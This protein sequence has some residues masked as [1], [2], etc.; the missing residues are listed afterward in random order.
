[1]Y[2]DSQQ[3]VR[4]QDPRL[5]DSLLI[6]DERY[7][8]AEQ[9]P[10]GSDSGH[11]RWFLE[12]KFGF[13]DGISITQA[14]TLAK[15]WDDEGEI[16]WWFGRRIA[17]S[18]VLRGQYRFPSWLAHHGGKAPSELLYE[19]KRYHLMDE[20]DPVA[21]ADEK[22]DFIPLTL[23]EYVDSE[24]IES[25]LIEQSAEGDLAVYHGAYYDP[26]DLKLS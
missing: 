8:V 9:C 21:P 1:M 18:D 2:D 23:W 5:N 26:A 19:G 12:G 17:P 7:R 4:V 6:E 14:A 22:A 10:C 24:E 15:E 3:D 11:V 25:L 16:W 20:A 13:G